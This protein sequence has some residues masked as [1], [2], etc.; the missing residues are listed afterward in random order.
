MLQQLLKTRY[1]LLLCLTIAIGSCATISKYD[2]YAYMETNSIKVDAVNIMAEAS[3]NYAVHQEEVAT[4]QTSIDKMI[5]YETN[6]P[7]NSISEK[8]WNLLNDPTGNL[9]GGFIARW[10]KEGKLDPVFIAQ[11]QKLVSQ[12][13]DQI[14]QLESGKI[15]PSST[16]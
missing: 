14:S 1:F 8:M 16:K 12:S 9:Y 3:D 15:K 10:K 4:L 7:K 2:Q 5:A 6:R 13:F 11:S